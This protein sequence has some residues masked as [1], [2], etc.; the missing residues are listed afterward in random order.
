MYIIS[1]S[2]D[3]ITLLSGKQSC[4]LILF[5]LLLLSL[6]P[7]FDTISFASMDSP[8]TAARYH[9]LVIEE[10]TF[11]HD[12]LEA[13]AWT[14]DGLIMA[15][16]HK[17]YKHIQV[18]L[19]PS[20]SRTGT[21]VDASAGPSS[22]VEDVYLELY[23]CGCYVLTANADCFRASNS[24][25]RASSPLRARKSSTT[26]TNS[27]RNWRSSVRREDVPPVAP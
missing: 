3:K 8:F 12:A 27:L 5:V 26:S 23:T 6:C 2:I 21:P 25:R 14:E 4:F 18:F 16:R 10:E 22:Q 11:P 24:T 7:R 9:S 15:A 19:L 1:L 17:K 13:T 20:A